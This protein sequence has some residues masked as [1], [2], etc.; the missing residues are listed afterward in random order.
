[1]TDISKVTKWL[2]ENTELSW[3]RTDGDSPATKQ[4]SYYINRSEAYEFRDLIMDFYSECNLTH[5]DTNYEITYKKILNYRKGDK[6]KRKEML[7]YL[8]S[9]SKK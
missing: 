5:K 9:S 2:R 8:I 7:E 1:M 6:V 3:T 4:D